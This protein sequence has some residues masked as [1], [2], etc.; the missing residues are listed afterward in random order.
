[1]RSESAVESECRNGVYFDLVTFIKYQEAVAEISGPRIF[2]RS[3][4]HC[5]YPVSE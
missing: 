3:F 2:P 5:D 4:E 1:M